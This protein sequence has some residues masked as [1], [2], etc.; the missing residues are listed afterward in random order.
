MIET[1]L[2]AL[3][4]PRILVEAA[5]AG[6]IS[7]LTCEM[8]ECK[9]PLGRDHFEARGVR[10][11]AAWAPSADRFPLMGHEGGTYDVDNVRLAHWRCNQVA[12]AAIGG[13]RGILTRVARG[14][15]QTEAWIARASRLGQ[16]PGR[17][18]LETWRKTPEGHAH[19]VALGRALADAGIRGDI[20]IA[21]AASLAARRARNHFQSEEWSEFSRK[22]SPEQKAHAA[23]I[24]L[25]VRWNLN[26]GKP[27]QCGHHATAS[28]AK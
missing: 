14:D 5:R 28:V 3:R 10:M 26:R 2:T 9:D 4:A 19:H 21:Q 7:R 1:E 15:F 23:R 25:C 16:G 6:R 13:H 17:Q 18:A 27:C 24:G 22:A 12:G 20:R 11:R 8:P